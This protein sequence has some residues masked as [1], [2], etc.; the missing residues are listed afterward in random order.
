MNNKKIK[1]LVV[2]KSSDKLLSIKKIIEKVIAHSEILLTES[3]LL[4]AEL[5]KSSAPDVIIISLDMAKIDD[6]AACISLKK[7][8]RTKN[9]PLIFMHA[10]ETSPQLKQRAIEAGATAFLTEPLDEYALMLQI[11]AMAALKVGQEEEQHSSSLSESLAQNSKEELENELARRIKAEQALVLAN[12]QLV[13]SQAE[14]QF[15][16]DCQKTML[17]ITEELHVYRFIGEKIQ[18]LIG[19]GCTIVSMLNKEEQAMEI[20]SATGFAD[21]MTKIINTVGYDPLKLRLKLSEMAA[22]NLFMY[23]SGSLEEITGG[24]YQLAC[25]KIPVAVCQ[26]LAAS[27][28][29]KKAYAIGLV[30]YGEDLGGVTI[31]S[32]QDIVKFKEAI[33]IIVNQA[34]L[35]INR[36]NSTEKLKASEENYR[37]IFEQSPIGISLSDS[38]N[39]RWYSANKKFL[40]IT[41]YSAEELFNLDWTHI[42]HPDDIEA[43]LYH[44][45]LMKAGEIDG[46]NI[47]KRYLRPDG[48]VV[49]IN[50]TIAQI[51]MDCSDHRQ[52]CM[53]EDITEKK[54]KEE[55]LS[56]LSYHDPLTGL[57]NRAYYEKARLR[58]DKPN[59]LPLSLITGDINGLKLIND[60]LGHAEGDKLIKEMAR[61]ILSCIRENDVLARVGGDEFSI[62]LPQTN[63]KETE[64]LLSCIYDACDEY[65]ASNADTKAFLSMSLGAATKYSKDEMFNNTEKTAENNMYKRKLLEHKS[66]HSSLIAS[67]RATLF[68]KSQETE[69]HAIRLVSLSR[70]L[71]VAL[72]LKDEQLNELELLATLHD[73]GKINI[74]NE[75]LNKTGK[76]TDEEWQEMKMHPAI[77]YRIAMASPE[78]EPIAKY[79]LTHHERWDGKGYPQG[80]RGNKIPLLS[81]IIS[82]ADAYDAMIEER[83]YGSAMSKEKA[84]AE[85]AQHAGTQFDPK[86]ANLFLAIQR[87]ETLE[88]Y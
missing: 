21:K 8:E 68:E 67:I 77:G 78:L 65:R 40:E 15:I 9:I 60:T 85:I 81:R 73:I 20:V 26:S 13:K 74:S 3:V 63:G 43:N 70:K 76:L 5:A 12:Q 71:G 54:T 48:S 72:S 44:L 66:F 31:F 6:F 11:Q 24:I 61:I 50:M 87:K 32:A 17:E 41:G 16:I 27:L 79:I 47:D 55:K 34:A 62:L 58:L 14:K 1:I 2:D 64:Y 88:E 4:G 29:I 51:K 59:Q 38:Y 25:Q 18:E 57:Y 33:E 7:A 80:L 45:A 35:T 46:F 37:A 49:W 56:Y 19:E 82:I 86:L 28:Q 52:L 69:A 83:P 84:I 10:A 23:Q 30:W 42:T 22:E 53:I 36:I 75:I 39:R